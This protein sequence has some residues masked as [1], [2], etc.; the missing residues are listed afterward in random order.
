[1]AIR[2]SLSTLASFRT[3]GW[4]GYVAIKLLHNGQVMWSDV[5][6]SQMSLESRRLRRAGAV[7]V[8]TVHSAD[9]VWQLTP[10][11][12]G[13]CPVHHP[14]KRLLLLMV[15]YVSMG[16]RLRRL[17]LGLLGTKAGEQGG[18]TCGP[19]TRGR[20][21]LGSPGSDHAHVPCALSSL[22]C[23]SAEGIIREASACKLFSSQC[24]R[25]ACTSLV[26]SAGQGAPLTPEPPRRWVLRNRHRLP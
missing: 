16:G 8:C 26:H 25:L 19:P 4:S 14:I 12:V 23:I 13:T 20:P 3:L 1:M 2:K 22:A 24:L 15:A 6:T 17:G 11:V 10:R 18:L 7:T 5:Y 21:P 9:T